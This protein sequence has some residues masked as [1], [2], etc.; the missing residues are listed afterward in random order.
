ME[1]LNES[2]E[3]KTPK[4][5]RKTICIFGISSFLGSNLAD[6]LKK[7][8]KVVGTYYKN[9]IKIDGVLTVPCD[10]LTKEEVQLVLFA[11]RP[12]IT[13]YSVGISSVL[14]CSKKEELADALNTSGLFNVAEYCQRYK[15]QICYISSSFVF[16]GEDKKYIEMD[17]PDA[18]TVYGKTQASA[19]FYIQKTSLNYVIFRCCKLYGRGVSANRESFFEK[20]QSAIKSGQNIN[21]DAFVS[22]G[23]LDVYYLAM[24]LKICFDKNVMNRLFQITTKDIG[25]FYDFSKS[26]CEVFGENS[27]AVSKGRWAFPTIAGQGNSGGDDINFKLDISNIESFL[28]ID[29]PTIKESLEF[30]FKRLNGEK[31]NKKKKTK[32]EG[33]NFI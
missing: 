16:A 10:V 17:I 6:F 1:E 28:N 18:N 31:N 32:G 14:D 5:K 2:S 24:I 23:Y 25:S 19:E 8:F 4:D 26:Y 33:V 20:L 22:T 13:I 27:S 12:D 11:F 29:L 21:A 3:K 15:S 7:D 9:P 30:T